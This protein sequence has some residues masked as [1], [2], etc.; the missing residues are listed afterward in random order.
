MTKKEIIEIFKV[1]NDFSKVQE[2][3]DMYINKY[4]NMIINCILYNDNDIALEYCIQNYKEIFINN[5]DY[6][7]KNSI[8]VYFSDK[9]TEVI[10][11]ARNN[12]GLLL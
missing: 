4:T 6:I 2:T 10:F 5:S 3:I 7:I 12:Y 9:C 11:N 8:N 1:S